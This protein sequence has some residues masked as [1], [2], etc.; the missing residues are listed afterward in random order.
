MANVS[1][2]HEEN[3]VDRQEILSIVIK[4]RFEIIKRLGSGSFG[5][6]FLIMWFSKLF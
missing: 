4:D 1:I 3:E 5:E 6:V 2:H